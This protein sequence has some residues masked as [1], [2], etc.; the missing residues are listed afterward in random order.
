MDPIGIDT[1]TLGRGEGLA[2]ELEQDA[3]EDWI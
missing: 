1:E 2:G 3:L